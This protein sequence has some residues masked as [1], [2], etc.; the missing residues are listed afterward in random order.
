MSGKAEFKKIF[1]F[2]NLPSTW[3]LISL[4]LDWNGEPLLLAQE[5]KPPYPRERDIEILS[6][7]KNAAPTAHHVVFFE[8]GAERI[9]SFPEA[10]GNITSFAQRYQDGWLLA[11]ARGG[12]ATI[13][14]SSGKPLQR[15]DLGD[16]SKDVQTT[17]QGSIWVSYFDEGVYGGGV[18]GAG[19]V[20][21]DGA[22]KRIFEYA[23]W[24]EKNHV[25]SIDDCYALNVMN[26]DEVWL[27]YYSDF[28]LVQIKRFKLA[29][30]WKEF[31]PI[32]HGFAVQ[33]QTVT[34]KKAYVRN[35]LFQCS[36]ENLSH[37]KELEIV[38]LD[39]YTIEGEWTIVARG[40]ALYLMTARALYEMISAE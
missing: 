10:R 12:S 30:I 31:G 19:L 7:W 16:A 32:A 11:D 17:D 26:D 20:C 38:D 15:L 9:V 1:D 25:P 34:Y 27:S 3:R 2:D 33:S 13:F 21:F 8:N 6:E 36:L 28:P 40:R 4:C 24:A 35:Q 22:G 29:N 37:H 39:G 23:E 18:G 14:G 5:G